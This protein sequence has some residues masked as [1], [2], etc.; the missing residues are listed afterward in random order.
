MHGRSS[1]KGKAREIHCLVARLRMG[2]CFVTPSFVGGRIDYDTV[3]K[4]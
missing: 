1:R 2:R 4:R 3:G